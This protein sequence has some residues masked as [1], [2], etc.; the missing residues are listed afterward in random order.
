MEENSPQKGPETPPRSNLV[1]G[2]SEPNQ[3][4]VNSG[5]SLDPKGESLVLLLNEKLTSF[6]VEVGSSLDEPTLRV[7][8]QQL[9][10][11]G[12]I[13]L[14]DLSLGFDYLR[15]LSVVDFEEFFEVVY[16]LW[17]MENRFKLT[18]KCT[19]PYDDPKV[20]SVMSIWKA[21]DWFEREGRDLFGVIFQGRQDLDPLLLW[22]GYDGFPGRKSSP[23]NEYEEW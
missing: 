11:I 8:P 5:S 16:H 20:P 23:F 14:K 18:V 2:N 21:A 13:L 19:T 22:E 6:N 7:D 1:Q 15:C 9:V 17:S 12:N 4:V 10:E 3:V